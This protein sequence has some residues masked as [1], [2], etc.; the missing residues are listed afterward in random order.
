[1]DNSAIKCQLDLNE[2]AHGEESYHLCLSDALA[3]TSFFFFCRRCV[4]LLKHELKLS[5]H[6]VLKRP[7]LT[8]SQQRFTC[9]R[10][11]RFRNRFFSFAQY[12]VILNLSGLIYRTVS[13][14]IRSIAAVI[15]SMAFIPVLFIDLRDIFMGWRC[16]GQRATSLFW[17]STKFSGKRICH[18]I[19]RGRDKDSSTSFNI[20]RCLVL[21]FTSFTENFSWSRCLIFMLTIACQTL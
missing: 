13:L 17:T 19:T 10:A 11:E 7:L 21:P 14:G 2:T 12:Q 1:M 18:W 20:R 15:P 3:H 4:S 16:V 6:S 8:T 5:F 9:I